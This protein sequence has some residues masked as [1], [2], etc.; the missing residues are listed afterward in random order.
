MDFNLLNLFVEFML[1][2]PLIWNNQNFKNIDD[3]GHQCRERLTESQY[4][5]ELDMFV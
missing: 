2:L 1:F 3:K 5:E 4:A